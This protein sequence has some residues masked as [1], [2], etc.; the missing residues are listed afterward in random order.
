[1]WDDGEVGYG[2][3]DEREDGGYGHVDMF[4]CQRPMEITL[5]DDQDKFV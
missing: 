3:M 1:M 2:P 5:N 4:A